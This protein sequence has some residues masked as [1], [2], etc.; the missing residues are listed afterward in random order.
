MNGGSLHTGDVNHDGWFRCIYCRCR[1]RSRLDMAGN[2]YL[3]NQDGTF[4]LASNTNL[5]SGTQGYTSFASGDIN[6]DGKTD[7][8]VMLLGGEN[9]AVYYNNGDNTFLKDV[10]PVSS[11]A[12]LM[13]LA[14]FNNDNK[15]DYFLFGYNDNISW[16]GVFV[17]NTITAENQAPVV[18]SNIIK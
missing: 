12:G 13:D 17:K 5:A 1:L 2:L 11:R 18:P 9:T 14:D 7:L 15:L 4:T 10:L 6:I 16:V 8:M 3:N